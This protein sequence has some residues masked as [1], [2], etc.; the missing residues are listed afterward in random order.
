MALVHSVFKVRRDLLAL[1]GASIAGG[2]SLASTLTVGG[3][4]CI[5]G[6]MKHTGA[7]CF[8]G[9]ASFDGNVNV[10]GA[11]SIVGNIKG[12]G[13]ASLAAVAVGPTT[14]TRV[15]HVLCGC[16][17]AVFGALNA[18]VASV[19]SYAVTGLTQDH[20]I[21]WS[22]SGWSGSLAVTS[23][24]CSPGGGILKIEVANQ[25]VEQYSGGNNT[26]TFLGLAACCL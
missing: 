4:A 7:A 26:F 17:V 22:P 23:M 11:A 25:A 19:T 18:S 14:G 2:A 5:V 1:K 24:S 16:A 20:K 10:A 9:A 8:T 6:T 21:F 12:S 15:A 3:A 13:T